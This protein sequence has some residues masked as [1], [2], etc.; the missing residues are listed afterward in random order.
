MIANDPFTTNGVIATTEI[1]TWEPVIGP[2]L[3]AI[4]A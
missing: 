1:T 3:P 4:Q 2:L